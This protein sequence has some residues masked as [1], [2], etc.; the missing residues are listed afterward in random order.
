VRGR[1]LGLRVVLSRGMNRFWLDV[2]VN[3]KVGRCSELWSSSLCCA[4]TSVGRCVFHIGGD[5]ENERR[6]GGLDKG[7]LS[8]GSC[9]GATP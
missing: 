6:S 2:M 7:L 5:V 8:I 4:S 3:Q 9:R 1:T